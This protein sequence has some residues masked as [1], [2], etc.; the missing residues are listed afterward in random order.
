MTDIHQQQHVCVWVCVCVC[1]C[2]G[3]GGGGGGGMLRPD[4]WTGPAAAE[5]GMAGGRSGKLAAP[6]PAPEPLCNAFQSL[7][8]PCRRNDKY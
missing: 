4:N 5:R 7:I 3:G 2:V 6:W 8:S 1:V